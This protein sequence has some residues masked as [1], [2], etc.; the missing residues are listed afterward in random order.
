MTIEEITQKI[1]VFRDERERAQFHSPKDMAEA[2]TIEAAELLEHFLWKRPVTGADIA[3]ASKTDIR[4][5]IADI[6]IYLS[7]L[8][9]NLQIGLLRGDG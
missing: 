7:E 8:A 6:G 3:E 4:E 9:D 5:E 2:N 1:R